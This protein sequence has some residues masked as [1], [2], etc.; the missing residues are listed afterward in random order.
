MSRIRIKG[1]LLE[2]WIDL[3][4]KIGKRF[5]SWVDLKYHDL[6]I[7]LSRELILSQFLESRWVMSLIASRLRDTAWVMSLFK[8]VCREG[9]YLS[10]KSQKVHMNWTLELKAPKRSYQVNSKVKRPKNVKRNWEWITSLSHELIRIKIL[11]SFLSR[12][13]IWIKI[14][15]AFWVPSRFESHFRNSFWV[16]S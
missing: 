7:H 12:E 6:G 5:E 16:V 8:S 4:R 15:Q 14:L 1:L 10:R 9:T 13:L 2:S 11:K 3:N